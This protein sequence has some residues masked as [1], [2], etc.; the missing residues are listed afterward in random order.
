MT[1]SSDRLP[2]LDGW[3]GSALLCVLASHFGGPEYLGRFGVDAFFVLSGILMAQLL[4]IK[5]QLLPEFFTRRAARVL[6]AFL[7]YA[8]SIYIFDFLVSGEGIPSEILSTVFFLRTYFPSHSDRWIS[9]LP[10]AHIWSLNVEEHSYVFLAITATALSRHR[11][12]GARLVIGSA[13]VSATFY[14]LYRHTP[15]VTAMPYAVRTECAAYP[16]LLAAG[17]Y[18]ASTPKAVVPR[19]HSVWAL[20]LLVLDVT[21]IA[22]FHGKM[23]FTHLISPTLLA[24]SI[25]GLLLADH[26]NPLSAILGWRPLRVVGTASFSLYLWQQPAHF[27]I[28]HQVVDWPNWLGLLISLSLGT[29]SFLLIER[30]ARRWLIRRHVQQAESPTQA[31]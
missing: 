21:L 24:V 15:P 10:L 17:L 16:L 7:A 11:L 31:C 12:S 25:N 19:H 5:K 9:E 14:L 26:K 8:A 30:P 13:L 2:W 20:A 1:P 3:R 28:Q 27:L 6:P 22:A 4:F 18:L 29:L 23:L